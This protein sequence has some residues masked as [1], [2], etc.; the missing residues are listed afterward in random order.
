MHYIGMLAAHY[1]FSTNLEETIHDTV[2]QNHARER[3]AFEDILVG[4]F[5]LMWAMAIMIMWTS[6]VMI[7]RQAKIIKQADTILYRIAQD[8]ATNSNSISA[9]TGSAQQA[10]NVIRNMVEQYVTKRCRAYALQRRPQVSGAEGSIVLE[11]EQ[12][13]NMGFVEYMV[14]MVLLLMTCQWKKLWLAVRMEVD[15]S[16]GGSSRHSDASEDR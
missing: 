11:K 2:L 13:Q 3:D 12:Q 10:P 14:H 15:S 1:R 16:V 6:R 4:S 9:S 5:V 8:V 7:Q